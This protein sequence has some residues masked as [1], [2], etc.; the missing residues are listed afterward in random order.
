MNE[1]YFG[2]SVHVS[3]GYRQ[4]YFK[5]MA[6]RANFLSMQGFKQAKIGPSILIAFSRRR[7]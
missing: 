3:V 7:L 6:R 4:F 5:S 2:A 1:L